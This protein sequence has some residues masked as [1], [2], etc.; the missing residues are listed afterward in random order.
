MFWE[1]LKSSKG[2]PVDD[3]IAALWGQKM[4]GGWAVTE[5]TGELPLAFLSDGSV[6]MNYRIYGTASG[7]GV[8]TENLF[9]WK[10]ETRNI[11]AAS[12]K[13]FVE[14]NIQVSPGETYCINASS[15]LYSRLGFYMN[16]TRVSNSNWVGTQ[17]SITIPDGCNYI[18]VEVRNYNYDAVTDEQ[19]ATATEIMLTS[20]STAPTSYIPPG[21]QVPIFLES[22]EHQSNYNL[23][24][25][26]SKLGE[27][28]YVEYGEQ[29]VYR[30]PNLMENVTTENGGI[31]ISYGTN[32]NNDNQTRIVGNI[33]VDNLKT[34][35]F[36]NANG[37]IRVYE[38]SDASFIG[39]TLYANSSEITLNS[40]TKHVRLAAATISWSSEMFFGLYNATPTD[41]PAPLPA[42]NTYKGENT[43]SSTETV[44]SV[45]V[46]GRIRLLNY[47]RVEYLKSTGTQYINTDIIPSYSNKLEATLQFGTSAGSGNRG[48]FIGSIFN[49]HRYAS[50]ITEDSS[51]FAL[52]FYCGY[53]WTS[54]DTSFKFITNATEL[55]QKKN[56]VLSS[57]LIQYGS[58]SK[59]PP[60][61]SQSAPEENFIVFGIRNT[62]NVIYPF[63]RLNFMRCYSL[64]FY[65]D[66]DNL[67][68]NLL[69][70]EREDGELGLLD[71]IT[72]KF[73]TNAGTG[74][75]EKGDYI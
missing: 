55:G 13:Q 68:H 38:Y 65:D 33:D 70:V 50:L 28:E 64:K 41:P 72:G 11:G 44:G 12:I 62:D 19:L 36:K 74:T 14:S 59:T 35:T 52:Y 54:S 4:S 18:Y 45:T 7:T 1:I 66:N 56:Y 31:D 27:E 40:N 43:L 73:Y 3:P 20:G 47:R 57:S 26:D 39:S 48:G 5:L 16:G 51:N 22:G 8:Q 21:Y 23:Y 58:S 6:L 32:V 61:V 29:K 60:P 25:G 46:R 34:Y 75:F 69:P 53:P 49:N 30:N 2:L 37:N 67:I 9:S 10:G 17:T 42:I 71:E 63:N 15:A 24:I